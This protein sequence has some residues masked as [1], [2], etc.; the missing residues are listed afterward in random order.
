M[1]KQTQT[2]SLRDWFELCLGGEALTSCS[3]LSYKQDIKLDGL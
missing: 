1:G 2:Q 3:N